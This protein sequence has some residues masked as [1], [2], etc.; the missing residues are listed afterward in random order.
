M[1]KQ[2]HYDKNEILKSKK[3]KKSTKI[4]LKLKKIPR[5]NLKDLKQPI[6]KKI[7]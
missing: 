5:K 7:S 6:N 4:N 1:W 2:K 3:K